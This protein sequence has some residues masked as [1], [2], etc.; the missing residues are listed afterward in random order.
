[1]KKKSFRG[2]CINKDFV[3]RFK[4]SRI[5]SEL[6]QK[7]RDELVLAVRNSYINLYYNCDS[8][9]KI[10]ANPNQGAK[11]FK[12]YINSYYVEGKSD[13]STSKLITID[14]TELINK[15]DLITANSDRRKKTEKQAQEKLFIANNSNASSNWY[16]IDLEFTRSDTHWRYDIIALSKSAPYRVAFIELKY[17]NKAIGGNSG[18]RKHVKDFYNFWKNND[19]D[20]LKPEILL[21]VHALDSLGV[22]DIP[23]SIKHLS[24]E[25][26]LYPEFYVVSLDN[27]C[28]PESGRRNTPKATM[29][30]YLFKNKWDDPWHTSTSKYSNSK[31]INQNG[32]YYDLIKNDHTFKMFFLFS[33]AKLPDLGITDIL[34]DSSYDKEELT[35]FRR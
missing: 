3:S 28:N 16:C 9:A 19:I 29:G 4:E 14:E 21:I 27:N 25:D 22:N 33:K 26:K 30:G 8:I 2:N 24:M 18:I 31:D 11:G 1:M 10:Y 17:G 12:V 5:F 35:K 32:D 15:F 13:N 34:D 7:H 6:Y 23:E 20:Q